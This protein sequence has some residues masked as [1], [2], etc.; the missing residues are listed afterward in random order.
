MNVNALKIYVAGPYS[1]PTLDL[2]EANVDQAIDVGIKLYRLGHLP[3]VPHLT[4]MIDLR[5]EKTG[6]R[7]EWEDFIRWDMPWLEASD[8]LLLLGHSKGADIELARAI[9]LGKQVFYDLSE[10]PVVPA[11]NRVS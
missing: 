8:A 10:V 3:Y 1:A 7:L 5:G 6:D 4:H 11:E 2:I 9:E